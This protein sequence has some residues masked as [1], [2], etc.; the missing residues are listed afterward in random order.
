MKLIAQCTLDRCT[1]LHGG[2]GGTQNRNAC[3]GA[4]VNEKK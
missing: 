4:A 3:V 2:G 1:H